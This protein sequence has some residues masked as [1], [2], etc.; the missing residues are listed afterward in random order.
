[1]EERD[2][3]QFQPIEGVPVI[4]IGERFQPLEL[5]VEDGCNEDKTVF[6]FVYQGSKK[7]KLI[8]DTVNRTEVLVEV[9][10]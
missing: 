6:W 8:I 1:M 3:Y 5:P 10:E 9:T 7:G 2:Y 4:Q